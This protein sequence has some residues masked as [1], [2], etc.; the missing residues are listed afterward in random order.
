MYNMI[1]S[2]MSAFKNSIVITAYGDI[3]G[4]TGLVNIKDFHCGNIKEE[5]SSRNGR[6][7]FKKDS[8]Y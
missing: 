8:V 4:C 2:W 6:K 7:V 1:H 5:I 3:T